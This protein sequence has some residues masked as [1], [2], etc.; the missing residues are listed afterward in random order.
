MSDTNKSN[1][2]NFIRIFFTTLVILSHSPELIDGNRD[3]EILTQLFYTI[4]FL[5]FSVDDFLS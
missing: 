5:K 3:R 4:S 2:F 1:N